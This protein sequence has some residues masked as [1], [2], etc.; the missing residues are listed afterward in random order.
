MGTAAPH[1]Q[2]L[3]SL[4]KLLPPQPTSAAL[5]QPALPTSQTLPV[6]VCFPVCPR[7]WQGTA[8]CLECSTCW[9]GSLI[10]NGSSGPHRDLCWSVSPG[11]CSVT[12]ARWVGQ[13]HGNLDSRCGAR[14][15]RRPAVCC[16]EVH[17]VLEEAASDRPWS[18]G[19]PLASAGGV[20]SVPWGPPPV[21]PQPRCSFP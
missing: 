19:P 4:G 5:C 8:Q 21:C 20:V 11:S 10:M 12:S 2:R 7:L 9:T 18:P 14:S 6:P 17:Q 13:A 1:G 15:A 3:P 16:V